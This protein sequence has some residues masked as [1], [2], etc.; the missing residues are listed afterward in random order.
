MGTPKQ[1][2]PRI[3]KEYNRN[4]RTVNFTLLVLYSLGALLGFPFYSL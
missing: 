1:G 3:Q 2:T 4:I